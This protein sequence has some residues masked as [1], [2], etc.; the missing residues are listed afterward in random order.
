MVTAKSMFS[1]RSVLRITV[2][3]FCSLGYFRPVFIVGSEAHFCFTLSQCKLF[4]QITLVT[5]DSHV[6]T[7]V[8]DVQDSKKIRAK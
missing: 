3:L 8:C 5:S 1:K 2:V 6:G 4:H 7:T